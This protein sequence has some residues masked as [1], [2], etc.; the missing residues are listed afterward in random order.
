V[1][2]IFKQR[3]SFSRRV[4]APEVSLVSPHEMRGMER[5][6]ALYSFTPFGVARLAISALASRRSIAAFHGS[7]RFRWSRAAL[8]NAEPKLRAVQP[9]PGARVPLVPVG[10]GPEPPEC[11]RYVAP[12]PQARRTRSAIK[13]PHE[14]APRERDGKQF[15]GRWKGWGKEFLPI[16]I[17]DTTR[18][19]C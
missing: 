12:R 14:R 13:T 2:S 8:A 6:K 11:A 7:S 16:Y 18:S 9:A 10:R 17:V 1:H 15:K 5:R 3:Y 19:I 4:F